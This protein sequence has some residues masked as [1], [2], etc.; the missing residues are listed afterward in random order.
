MTREEIQATS[1]VPRV[2]RTVLFADVVE[3]VRMMEDDEDDAVARVRRLMEMVEA[4]VLPAVGGHLFKRLGDGIMLDFP[5]VRPAVQAAFAIQRE[6]S[7]LNEGVAPERQTRLRI[8]LHV[9]ELL[10]DERDAYGL[11]VSLA[12]RLTALAGPGEIVGS[13]EVRDRL[14]PD[15]DADIE[16]LGEC[17]LRHVQRPVRVYRIGPPGPRPADARHGPPVE[18]LYPAIAVI[19]FAARTGEPEHLVFGEVLAE[20]II[21]ALS[22]AVELNLISRL[23]TTAFRGR[24]ATIAEVSRRL[25][26]NYVLSGAYSVSGTELTLTAVLAEAKSNEIVWAERLKGHVFGIINGDDKLIDRVVYGVSKEVMD[27]ELERTQA[28]ALPTLE[29]YSL[30]MGAIA[31]MHRLSASD[32]DRARQMLEVLIDRTPRQAVPYA[33][34]GKWHV[35][36]VQ[37]GWSDDPLRDAGRGLDC[38]KRALDMDPQCSLALAIDGFIHTNLLKMLDVANQRYE[39]ALRVNPNDSLAWLLKGTLHAFKGEG[40]SAVKD[41]RHALRLSPLDPLRYFYD[42]LAAT[43]A[44]SAGS[45]ERAMELARRSLRANRTH[46]S[47]L[48]ALAV[49][50]WHCGRLEE[51]RA[52]VRELLRLDPTFTVSKFIERSPSTGYETGRIWSSTLREAGVPA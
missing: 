7:R 33:W 13:A 52:T 48:R 16:D 32:F 2:V 51:S 25:D 1:R 37:Q 36:R 19:P 15:L 28:R 45:Y 8:G 17:Y 47:T 23:S 43:A 11:D 20:E 21:S 30:L 35:L 49:A 39:L 42:S 46:T 22:R 4:V 44:L 40:K 34:M 10:A 6:C 50:Q 27:R 38:T 29:S 14:T 12:S 41:T 3:S 24:G 9:C 5:E 31:L 18:E 26:A